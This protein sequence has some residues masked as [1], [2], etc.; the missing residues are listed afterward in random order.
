LKELLISV[1]GIRGVVGRSFTSETALNYARAFGSLLK[2]G[3]VAVG[4]DT[5]ITGPMFTSA[6][7]SGLL[8][9]GCDVADI[10]ICPTPT[11]ELAVR[12]GVFN[13]GV[14]VTASHNPIEYN[15]LKLIG[16]DGVFLSSRDGEKVQESFR[17]GRF[18]DRD[19]SSIGKM[20]YENGWIDFHIKRILGLD[21]I[22]VSSI[23]RRGLKIVADCGGGAASYMAENFF[24]K[25]GVEFEL[26][27][28]NP[29][30]RFPRGPEPVPENL[31][32][33][34]RAVRRKKADV[35]FAFDPDA[36]RLAIVSENGEPIGEEYT[37]TLGARYILSRKAGPV[38]VNLSSSMMNDFV[39]REAGVKIYR[40]K[41]GERNVT[42]KL[43]RLRGVVGGEGNGG[44]IYPQLHWGRDAF[45]AAAVIVQYLVS[46]GLKIDDLVMELPRYVMIKTKINL[47]RSDV[48]KRLD[49]LETVFQGDKINR[50]DGIKISGKEWWVQVRAS[51][52]EPVARIISEARDHA[53]AM[54]LIKTVKSVF[55]K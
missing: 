12:S 54:D 45:L 11:V 31:S 47:T 53:T 24:K 8:S 48:E 36:D 43:R 23:K 55:R 13:G 20:T 44:L 9:S 34:S 38:A 39:A 3:K 35:G 42:E 51:N 52:T 4:R 2:G 25:L 41:V 14:A 32:D 28:S 16:K 6:V 5:R 22:S 10:G 1:S 15:A 50:M 40:T 37:L 21:I 46:S 33:L 27:H 30:G 19:W 26:I 18:R 17:S 7:I 29:T 49:A